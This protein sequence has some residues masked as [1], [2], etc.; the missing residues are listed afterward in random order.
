MFDTHTHCSCKL[1]GNTGSEMCLCLFPQCELRHAETTDLNNTLPLSADHIHFILPR[2][3][4]VKHIMSCLFV[5]VAG[6]ITGLQNG[7]RMPQVFKA[8][9]VCRQ[10][11]LFCTYVSIIQHHVQRSL[12]YVLLLLST[13]GPSSVDRGC[14]C[15]VAQLLTWTIWSDKCPYICSTM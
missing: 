4:S 13:G 10:L 1:R 3:Y 15:S 8:H 9:H 5:L 6:L 11:P 2:S 12:W 14:S 7:S